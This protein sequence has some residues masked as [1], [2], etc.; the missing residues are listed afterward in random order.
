MICFCFYHICTS[1]LHK[2]IVVNENLLFLR[3]LTIESQGR[4]RDI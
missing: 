1:I 2:E 4:V 3:V